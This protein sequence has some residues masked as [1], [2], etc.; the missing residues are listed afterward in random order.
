MGI[1]GSNAINGLNELHNERELESK[2]SEEQLK[3]FEAMYN[4]VADLYLDE[5]NAGDYSG[6]ESDIIVNDF[7]TQNNQ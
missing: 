6:S 4:S 7:L 5:A 3:K 2:Y 1:N